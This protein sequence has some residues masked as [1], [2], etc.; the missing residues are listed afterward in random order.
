MPILDSPLFSFQ[1]QGRVGDVIYSYQAKKT[2]GYQNPEHPR[3]PPTEKQLA[4]QKAFQDAAMAWYLKTEA[5]KAGWERWAEAHG[6]LVDKAC[7]AAK[8][9]GMAFFI[10]LFILNPEI[11]LPVWWL[12]F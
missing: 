12:I 4:A 5:E 3:K 2:R 8:V 6:P 9:A 11:V 10:G 1:A 7:T